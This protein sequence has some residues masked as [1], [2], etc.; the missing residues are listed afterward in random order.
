MNTTYDP[1]A[2]Q[3]KTKEEFIRKMIVATQEGFHCKRI[4]AFVDGRGP[5]P[6]CDSKVHQPLADYGEFCAVSETMGRRFAEVAL[7]SG[8]LPH[9][10]DER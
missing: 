1:L 3:S 2:G 7:D 9:L 5:V 10:N 6:V 8:L 4:V